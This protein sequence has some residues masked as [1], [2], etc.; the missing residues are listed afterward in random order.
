[1]NPMPFRQN[2]AAHEL[3]KRRRLHI[4]PGPE[5]R[6]EP[7]HAEER[8][9]RDAGG[10]H[11]RACYSCGCGY[12]FEAPVSASVQCPNCRTEQAW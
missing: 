7:T 9:L 2:K 11:D 8:R 3:P 1:M 12:L 6:P 10:P 4:V 5:P